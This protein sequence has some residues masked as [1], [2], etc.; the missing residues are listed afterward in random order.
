MKTLINKLKL[1]FTKFIIALIII[2]AYAALLISTCYAQNPTEKI[3][4]TIKLYLSRNLGNPKSYESISWSI[5]DTV[6]SELDD[7]PKYN[8]FANQQ[9]KAI[10]Y[11]DQ[12]LQ[13]IKDI[14]NRPDSERNPDNGDILIRTMK[15]EKVG[16]KPIIGLPSQIRDTMKLYLKHVN[17]FIGNCADSINYTRD[18][19]K[20]VP[21]KY[22][23][24]HQY[25]A[26]N[27]YGAYENFIKEFILNRKFQVIATNFRRG[28]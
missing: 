12:L 9:T 16:G 14:S 2:T 22:V 18:H 19:Y 4:A 11:R 7:S 27:Y 26:T 28:E 3:R 8:D 23:I 20:S 15:V 24:S 1:I 6:W 25:R 5:I 10:K 17:T 13:D 21:Y